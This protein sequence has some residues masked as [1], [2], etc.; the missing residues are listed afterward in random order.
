[1]IHPPFVETWRL[2][3]FVL[4]FG[5]TSRIYRNKW[6]VVVDFGVIVGILESSLLGGM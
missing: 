4:L 2:R 3:S 1:M 6:F 5:G